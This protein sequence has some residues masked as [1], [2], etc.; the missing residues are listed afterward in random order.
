MLVSDAINL[1]CHR[2]VAFLVFSTDAP[3]GN[4][5]TFPE[6]IKEQRTK[7][8]VLEESIITT[9]YNGLKGSNT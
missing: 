6:T 4:S 9:E 3:P 1:R 2:G 5:F 8:G 7:H